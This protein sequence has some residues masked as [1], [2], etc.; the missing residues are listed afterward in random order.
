VSESQSKSYNLRNGLSL[1]LPYPRPCCDG[2]V[3]SKLSGQ[4]VMI[5]RRSARAARRANLSERIK[6]RPG[7]DIGQSPCVALVS[8]IVQKDQAEACLSVTSSTDGPSMYL[9]YSIVFALLRRI[10]RT[11]FRHHLC[12]LSN[13][14]STEIRSV[15][16]LQYR[17]SRWKNATHD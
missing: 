7:R 8:E 2:S 5:D 9:C 13:I 3:E 16:R 15:K 12:E 11:Y 10:Q 6:V 17:F 1:G 14:S 4:D